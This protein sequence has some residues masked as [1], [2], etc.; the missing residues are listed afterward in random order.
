M[1]QIERKHGRRACHD[2]DE[3]AQAPESVG[4]YVFQRALS[5]ILQQLRI[6]HE[7]ESNHLQMRLL[8][9]DGRRLFSSIKAEMVVRAYHCCDQV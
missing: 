4:S 6:A 1:N 9:Y 3:V 8:L 5:R 7:H 2:D